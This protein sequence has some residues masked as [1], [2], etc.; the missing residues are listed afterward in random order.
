MTVQFYIYLCFSLL[1]ISAFKKHRVPRGQSCCRLNVSGLKDRLTPVDWWA[2]R[3]SEEGRTVGMGDVTKSDFSTMPSKYQGQTHKYQ[4]QYLYYLMCLM[5][6][7]CVCGRVNASLK[8][9]SIATKWSDACLNSGQVLTVNKRNV[10]YLRI[11]CTQIKR[12]Q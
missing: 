1:N 9:D 7:M 3:M 2:V 12:R 6:Y 11:C 4:Y 5:M 10:T 8:H